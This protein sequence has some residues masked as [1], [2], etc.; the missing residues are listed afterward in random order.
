VLVLLIIF[1]VVTP[2]LTRGKNVQLPMA[3]AADAKSEAVDAIVVT[4]TADKRLWLETEKVDDATLV[5]ELKARLAEAPGV[6]VLIKADA[7]VNVRDLRPVLQKLKLAGASKIAFAVHE[8]PRG[9]K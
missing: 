4:I 3:G 6:E 5:K 1:M 7:S 8:Q 9:A 2:M